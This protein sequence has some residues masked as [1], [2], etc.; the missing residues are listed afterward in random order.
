MY[1]QWGPRKVF[2]FKPTPKKPPIENIK[3]YDAPNCSLQADFWRSLLTPTHLSSA[4]LFLG[5]L[6]MAAFDLHAKLSCHQFTGA[7]RFWRL[8]TVGGGFG[9]PPSWGNVSKQDSRTLEA[10]GICGEGGGIS[11]ISSDGPQAARESEFASEFSCHIHGLLAGH[12]GRT[13]W[14]GSPQGPLSP[15]ILLWNVSPAGGT[16]K[17]PTDSSQ[18]S[19]SKCP[20]KLVAA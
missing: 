7:F 12:L 5:T 19:K 14:W 3:D 4:T 15:R 11:G 13:R 20:C 2:F 1:I 9:G 16:A 6:E 10:P 18:P 17:T 8:W